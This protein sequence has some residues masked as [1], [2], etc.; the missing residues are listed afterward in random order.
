[1]NFKAAV[2]IIKF[3]NNVCIEKY[4]SC[5]SQLKE[6]FIDATLLLKTICGYL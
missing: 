3:I 2:I 6:S 1:M 5:I 4:N